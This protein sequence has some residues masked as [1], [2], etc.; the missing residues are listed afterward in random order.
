MN[1]RIIAWTVGV[2]VI[3]GATFYGG[4]TYGKS[5]TPARGQV[6]NGQ[7]VGGPN[8]VRGTGTRGGVSGG[9]FT[10]GEIISKDAGSITVKMQDGSTKIVL[11]A[12]STQVMKSTVGSSN[13]LALGIT[14]TITGTAN[15]D[16]SVSAQNVQI[17]PAGSIPSGG[18]ARTNQ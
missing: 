10:V 15:S 12:S 7:F 6:G 8:G 13:D 2:V 14:V 9:G 5:I 17:R 18:G 4:M 3:A 11:V 1:K 16:G